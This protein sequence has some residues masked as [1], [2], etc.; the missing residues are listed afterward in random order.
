MAERQIG[1][2]KSRL[3]LSARF[4]IVNWRFRSVAKSAY[5][6]LNKAVILYFLDPLFLTIST[7]FEKRSWLYK[8]PPIKFIVW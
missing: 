7:V 2:R 3:V 5:F 6:A 4:P 1:H 8:V